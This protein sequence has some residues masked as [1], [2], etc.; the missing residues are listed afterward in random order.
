VAL[1]ASGVRGDPLQTARKARRTGPLPVAK[2]R[3]TA[4]VNPTGVTTQ[5]T[6]CTSSTG[7]IPYTLGSSVTNPAEA[8]DWVAKGFVTPI[9]NQGQC[10]SCTAFATTAVTE[11]VLMNRSAAGVLTI[12]GQLMPIGYYTNTNIETDPSE[13]DLMQCE[14]ENATKAVL[15]SF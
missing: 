1:C 13:D 8:I 4:K 5:A 6:G 15:C 3:R 7:N 9:R 10:G 2:K 12:N 14:C 11:W